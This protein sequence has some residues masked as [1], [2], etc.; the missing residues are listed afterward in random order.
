MIITVDS[1]ATRYHLLPSQVMSDATTFDLFIMDAAVSW[2]NY[3]QELRENG[4]KAPVPKL[5][6]EQMQQM[7]AK[8]DNK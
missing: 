3:Q 2:H 5:T 1:I 4:G 6:Q 8:V 7:L